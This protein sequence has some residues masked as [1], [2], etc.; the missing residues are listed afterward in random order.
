MMIKRR[1][2]PRGKPKDGRDASTWGGEKSGLSI[3]STT[4]ILP[5]SHM[6]FEEEEEDMGEKGNEKK[7]KG[8]ELVL[9]QSKEGDEDVNLY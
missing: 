8:F 2:V 4:G 6:C 5:F 9:R 3:A 1:A 7:E